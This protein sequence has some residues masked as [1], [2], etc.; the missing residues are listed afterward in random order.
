MLNCHP[1]RPLSAPGVDQN[2]YGK[3]VW[4]VKESDLEQIGFRSACE[5]STKMKK[6]FLIAHFFLS[7]SHQHILVLGPNSIFLFYSCHL[8]NVPSLSQSPAYKAPRSAIGSEDGW[9]G[10]RL[11]NYFFS[12]QTSEQTHYT[13]MQESELLIWFSVTISAVTAVCNG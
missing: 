13:K 12:L 9:Q 5:S 11:F 2:K 10:N 4:W 7:A 1:S 3:K 6:A 8:V